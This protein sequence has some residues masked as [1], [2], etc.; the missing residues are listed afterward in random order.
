V[1]K[2]GKTPVLSA[3]EM[4]G[5]RFCPR[6]RGVQHQCIYRVDSNRD[7]GPLAPLVGRADRSIDTEL[8]AEQWDRMGQLYASRIAAATSRSDFRILDLMKYERSVSL[9]LVIPVKDMD[10]M[11]PLLHPILNQIVKGLTPRMNGAKP[12]RKLLLMLDELCVL[13]HMELLSKMLPFIPGYGIR[14]CLIAQNLKQIEQAYGRD[15]SIVETCETD[16][17]VGVER[18]VRRLEGMFQKKREATFV[19]GIV[20]CLLQLSLPNRSTIQTRT[21]LVAARVRAIF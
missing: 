15:Q 11:Q 18:E 3:E 16:L 17:I 13:G 2:R 9:Y 21:S 20:M 1:V 10:R 5:L 12:P 14:A 8:I 7:Y 6:I 19:E 4:L